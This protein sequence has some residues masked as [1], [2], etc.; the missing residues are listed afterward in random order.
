MFH[1]IRWRIAIPYVVLILLSTLGLT[2]FISNQVRKVRLADLESQLVAEAR[3]LVD[4]LQPLMA[5]GESAD[6]LDSLARRWADLLGA[7]VTIIG[8]DGTVLGESQHDRTEMGN[9]LDRPEVQQALTNGQGSSIRFS[10]TVGYEMMYVALPVRAPSGDRVMGVVRVALPL[11]QIEASVGRLRQTILTAGLF[12]ALLAAL[13]ALLIAERTARPVRRLTGVAERMAEGDLGARLLPTSRDEVGQLTLAF[14][15]MADQLRE[16]VTTLAEEQDRLAVVLEHMA[17]GVL[18]TDPGG[19]VQ[20]I[21]PAAAR[22]LGTTQAAALG[23]SFVQV[24]R[25]HRLVELWENCCEQSEEQSAAV[26]L[27]RLGLFLQVI[28]TPLQE[29][30]PSPAAHYDAGVHGVRLNSQPKYR[31]LQSKYRHLQPKYRHLQPKYRHLQPKYRQAQVAILQDLTQIRRLDTVRRDFISNISHE[32]RTPLASL[33]ALVDTLRDGALDDPPAAQR[34]LDRI[35]T[36]V[37]AMTQ[38]VQELLELS[39][40]ESGR[41]PLSLVPTPVADVVVPSVERLYP[42]AERAGLG[43]TVDLPSDLPQVLADAERVREVVTNLVHNAIKFTRPGGRVT[44][45]AYPV[46]DEGQ[47]PEADRYHSAVIIEVADT[48]VGIPADDL[49]RIFERF[50][51]ADRARSGGGT[52]L[53]LAI[54]KHV[55]QGHGGRIWAESIEGQGS[56][57]YFTLLAVV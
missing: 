40:I 1:T 51:K 30:T 26:E 46:E 9:H 36:E 12:T 13:M 31:H 3:V 11:R 37:D 8:V 45:R 4:S 24:V 35:E 5:Q 22:L 18:I 27:D 49:P 15:H 43:L 47:R 6:A 52:G 34:F 56:T 20:L 42:Q 10:Q 57:F 55:V 16:K 2:F 21:N 14:N 38:M 29:I 28:V 50:Y 44:V 19:R 23:R 17:D 32:L 33:K 41:V 7:R 48:G 53:G 25:D 54:A 39:R